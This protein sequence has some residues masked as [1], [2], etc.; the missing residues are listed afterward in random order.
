MIEYI[1][2]RYLTWKTGKDKRQRDQDTWFNETVNYRAKD[3]TDMFKN[4]KHVIIVNPN[5]FF[6]HNEPFGWVPVQDAKQYFYP[7][8]PLDET[9]VWTF[10]RVSWNKWDDRWHIDEFGGED[11]V[12][13]ACNGSKDAAM[14]VLKYS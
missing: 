5:L 11:K 7:V 13:V 4:F 12:F 9:C 14:I 3:I 8:R 10:E 2:D 6:D 1:K